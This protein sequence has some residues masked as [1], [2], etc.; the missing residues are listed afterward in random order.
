MSYLMI[1]ETGEAFTANEIL[2]AHMQEFDAG[3]LD[4]FD[5]SRPKNVTRLNE[6]LGW[7]E[8]NHD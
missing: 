2:E 5:I 3:T 6:D 7:D 8:V 4:I 1:F